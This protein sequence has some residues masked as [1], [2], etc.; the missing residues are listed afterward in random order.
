MFREIPL[1]VLAFGVFFTVLLLGFCARVFWD[2]LLRRSGAGGA[3][4]Q[5][6]IFCLALRFLSS[7]LLRGVCVQSF[8]G[9]APLMF[10]AFFGARHSCWGIVFWLGFGQ[11]TP[12]GFSPGRFFLG[13]GVSSLFLSLPL[14]LLSPFFLV[15]GL[16]AFACSSSVRPAG[17]RR[18]PATCTGGSSFCLPGS[19]ASPSLLPPS[20]LS[21]SLSLFS[22]LH[23]C[24]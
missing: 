13:S 12:R 8:V 15:A 2:E 18:T 14:L 22:F 7:P 1:I 9:R 5:K 6:V 11:T 24:D 21:L 23:A 10:R 3:P 17:R 16:G 20:A 19:V 4:R